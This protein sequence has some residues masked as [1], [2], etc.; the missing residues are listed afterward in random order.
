M[1]YI[2][3][4]NLSYSYPDEE[5]ATIKD[6]NLQIKKGEILFLCGKSGSGK[7][8][9]SRCFTGAVPNF[10]GG[11]ISG[12]V[13]IN[14]KGLEELTDRERAELITMVFQDPEKQILMDKVLREIAFG[15]E[16]IGIERSIIKRRVIETMQFCNILNLK[17]RFI[18]TLSGGEKQKVSIASALVYMPKCIVF[19]EPTSQLDPAASEEIVNLIRKINQELGITIIV[20]EQRT[21]KFFEIADRIAVMDK[22]SII[23]CGSKSDMYENTSDEVN[24]FLPSFLKAARVLNINEMPNSFRELRGNLSKYNIAYS[25]TENLIKESKSIIDIKKLVCKYDEMKAVDDINLNIRQGSFN[26]IIG[27]NG[28]GK[29]TLMKAIMGFTQYKG[30]IKICGEEVKKLKRLGIKIGYV[31]QNPNDYLSKDTVYEELKFTLNNYGLK[32]EKLIDDTLKALDIYKLKLK[33]PRDLSGGEKQRAAIASVLVLKPEIL[34]LDE[35]TRGL[36]EEAKDR[37]GG[38]LKSLNDSRG[39]ILMITHDMDFAAKFC[40]NFILMF[41]GKVIAE[42]SKNRVLNQGIYYTTN[43]NK[44]FRDINSNIF[45]VDDIRTIC[46]EKNNYEETNF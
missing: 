2:E 46:K 30:S 13:T 1:E 4:K 16:N 25:C 23:F 44:L 5:K 34:I 40:D 7:S 22:G 14:N 21:D 17:D 11:T 12:E 43:I 39:T 37:L 20:I 32:D 6:I 26:G 33:N 3:V 41:E 15:I 19:D 18:K 29:S 10:Y 31:S 28:A 42:G 24:R 9:L 45:V 35:P 27:A 36:D 8:T 38:I